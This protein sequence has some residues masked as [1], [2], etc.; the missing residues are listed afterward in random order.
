MV[1][2]PFAKGTLIVSLWHI[3][4]PLFRTRY[5]HAVTDIWPKGVIQ[6]DGTCP[7]ASLSVDV[8]YL[9]MEDRPSPL[10]TSDT[11]VLLPVSLWR[12]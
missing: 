12:L 2:A 1:N 6:M 7:S 3:R 11:S 5:N 8:L 9:A 4:T 10:S